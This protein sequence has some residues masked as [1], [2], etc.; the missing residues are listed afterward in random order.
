M[1]AA[2]REARRSARSG[3]TLLDVKGLKTHFFTQD[4]VVKAVDGVSLSI[5]DGKTLGVVGE[6]GCG[7]SVAAMSILRLIGRPG[8]IA[9]APPLHRGQRLSHRP[10]ARRHP[11]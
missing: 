3:T 8:R 11:P 10:N 7:K 2:T 6:S 4:G 1:T 9:P 5:D